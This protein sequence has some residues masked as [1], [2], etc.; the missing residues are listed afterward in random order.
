MLKVGIVAVGRELLTGRVRDTNSAWIAK[1]ATSLGGK[2]IRMAVVDDDPQ[3]IAQEVRR[4]IQE[5][6]QVVITTG[7][8]GPTLDDR[9]LEG[10]ALA[11][12]RPLKLNPQALRMVEERY[13]VLANQG[14]VQNAEM[15]EIRRKMAILP[16]GS[17]PLENPVGA[18]PGVL[19]EAEAFV[20]SLPGVPAEM[21]ALFE[22]SVLGF[23]KTLAPGMIYQERTV[24]TGVGDESRL[25]PVLQ[26]VMRKVPRVYCKSRATRFGQDVSLEVILSAAGLEGEIETLLDKAEEELRRRLPGMAPS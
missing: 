17:K 7:G 12:G 22:G 1:R 8:L 26:E 10:I 15:D 21:E 16:E 13:R 23:L 11:L 18:A 19:L 6:A 24:A 9:T 2:V 4:L 3:A 14:F 25:A 20:V 5:G